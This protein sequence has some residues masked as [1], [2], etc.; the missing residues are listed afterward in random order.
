RHQHGDE[1][2]HHHRIGHQ[3]FP[4]RPDDLTQLGDDFANESPDPPKPGPTAA[5][6]LASTGLGP[7]ARLGLVELVGGLGT[8]STP[9][10]HFA[11]FLAEFSASYRSA[12]A[13]WPGLTDMAGVTGLEPATYGFGDRCA[14]NCA[15]P[16]GVG[17]TH[18]GPVYG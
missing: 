17:L 9:L 15:T 8:W 7:P 4:G 14:A 11:L 10:S 2:D 1:E 5:A 3:L 12:P 6:A 16:L 13:T 18:A